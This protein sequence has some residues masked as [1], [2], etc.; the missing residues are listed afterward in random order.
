[1]LE[2][3][4]VLYGRLAFVFSKC[5][6]I[7]ISLA[8]SPPISCDDIICERL[9]IAQEMY[10]FVTWHQDEQ[11]VCGDSCVMRPVVASSSETSKAKG[12]LSSFQPLASKLFNHHTKV[13]MYD[14]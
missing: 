13:C 10:D 11:P 9:N 12:Y 8:S 14:V 6:N 3:L 2:Q 5:C 7:S 4:S 1:M